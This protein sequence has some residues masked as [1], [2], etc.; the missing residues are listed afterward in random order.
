M[1]ILI[2]LYVWQVPHITGRFC[3][4]IVISGRFPSN[5]AGSPEP[6]RLHP[7]EPARTKIVTFHHL[8]CA[9]EI[10]ILNTVF[11]SIFYESILKYKSQQKKLTTLCKQAHYDQANSK[12]YLR[13]HHHKI[14]HW[15]LW[16]TE[17]TRNER[18][19]GRYW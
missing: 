15:R 6:V 18:T 3:I 11:G 14:C 5:L 17:W 12:V 1:T 16:M 13:D 2:I 9:Y 4:T 8:S 10:D 7:L 19:E